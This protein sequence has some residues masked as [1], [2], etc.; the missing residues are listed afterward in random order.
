MLQKYDQV[1]GCDLSVFYR[2]HKL[3]I[4]QI[5]TLIES[6]KKDR[7]KF[8]CHNDATGLYEISTLKY[9]YSYHNIGLIKNILPTLLKGN[10]EPSVREETKT[11]VFILSESAVSD[12]IETSVSV[13]INHLRKLSKLYI[14]VSVF[15]ICWLCTHKKS[16][17]T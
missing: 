8:D 11:L 9:A 12:K 6:L 5:H 10:R 17:I 14:V 3:S 1:H 15:Y 7:R 16:R 4:I 13:I 2:Y